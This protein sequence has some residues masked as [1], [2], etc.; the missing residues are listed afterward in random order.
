MQTNHRKTIAQLL[1][2]RVGTA[3]VALAF[4]VTTLSV[5]AQDQTIQAAPADPQQQGA[6][7]SA[8]PDAPPTASAPDQYSNS[9]NPY[10][11]NQSVPATLT[12]PAGTVVSVRV[13]G[14]I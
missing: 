9:P 7:P 8:P 13:N 10:P 3:A 1:C 11:A 2:S 14:W 4:C 5:S 6:G 12:L